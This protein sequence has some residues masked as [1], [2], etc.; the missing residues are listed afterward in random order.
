MDN[1]NFNTRTINDVN[2]DLYKPHNLSVKYDTTIST[3]K[4]KFKVFR[5]S[6]PLRCKIEFGGRKIEKF[7]HYNFHG[8]IS[9]ENKIC[10]FQ[11]EKHDCQ[12]IVT[13]Q[14]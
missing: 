14:S 13:E 1:F 11:L 6:E 7:S 5:G 8:N 9:V 12:E 4:T 3:S 2:Y 10:R